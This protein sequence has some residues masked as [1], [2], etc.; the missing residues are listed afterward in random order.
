[1]A[2]KT[3]DFVDQDRNKRWIRY[4]WDTLATGDTGAPLTVNRL[5]A[6]LCFQV[7]GTFAN[8]T[9][10]AI[11]GSND[12]GSTWIDLTDGTGSVVAITANGFV[13]VREQPLWVRPEAT[14]GSSDDVDVRLVIRFPP[15]TE[16]NL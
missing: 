3:L 14:S 6:E 5:A 16:G 15:G 7:F 10:I 8:G 1:M 13:S 4:K 11:Q 9:V 2:V 12:D